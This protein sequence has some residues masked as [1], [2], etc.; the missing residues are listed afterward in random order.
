V[1]GVTSVIPR[2]SDAK[3]GY[4]VRRSFSILPE[5]LEYWI[6]RFRG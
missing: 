2:E 6:I 5:A 3:A 1:I 4:P